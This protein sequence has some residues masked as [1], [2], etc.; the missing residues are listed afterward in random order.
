MPY[1]KTQSLN[2]VLQNNMN[3][4]SSQIMFCKNRLNQQKNKDKPCFLFVC[5]GERTRTSMGVIP[6]A[7][8]A[9]VYTNFTTPANIS[10]FTFHGGERG[11]RTLG[12][13]ESTSVFKTDAFDHSAISP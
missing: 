10:N 11:I 5:A 12:T 8:K 13:R 7:P 3:D 9:G 6:H 2:V 4:D 1:K